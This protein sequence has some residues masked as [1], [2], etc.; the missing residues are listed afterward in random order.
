MTDAAANQEEFLSMGVD[1]AQY[2]ALERDFRDVL[3]A[4]VGEKSMERFRTEYEKLHR[5]LKTSYESE[6]RLVKRCKELNE[7]IMGNATRVKAALKLTQEDS[8]TITVL[9]REVD[10]AWRLVEQAKEKE[11]KARKIIQDLK[12]EIAHLHKIVEQGSGLTFSQDNN[13]QQML[14]Q[15][16]ALQQQLKQK[17]DAVADLESAKSGIQEHSNRIEAEL[18]GLK[19]Q[20]K[21]SK[22]TNEEQSTEITR[23]TRNIENSKEEKAAA[24][25]K[26][27]ELASAHN[28]LQNELVT[29]KKEKGSTEEQNKSLEKKV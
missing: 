26:K 18:L 7:T 12:G 11:E 16:Q 24:E 28:E 3:S 23:M 2:E 22:I 13:V 21:K 25:K 9:K 19:E 6:K 14:Q 17:D 29:I 4:M 15:K 10:R 27:G 8:S 1:Q 20:L 5:A